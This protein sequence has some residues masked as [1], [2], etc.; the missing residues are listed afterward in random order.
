M[1]EVGDSSLGGGLSGSGKDSG[2]GG[3]GD[4]GKASDVGGGS[5][6]SCKVFGS[7]LIMCDSDLTGSGIMGSVL[8]DFC[9][10]IQGITAG[11]TSSVHG[12]TAGVLGPVPISGK[13]DRG[14]VRS[15]GVISEDK[16]DDSWD[17][18]ISHTEKSDDS[19]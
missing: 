16:M 10:S 18:L 12:G 3:L 14:M 9:P 7:G 8:G 15:M 2:L 5:G 4:S 1:G 19:G 6:G 17:G 11:K 13:S